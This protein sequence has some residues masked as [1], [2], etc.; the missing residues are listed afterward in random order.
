MPLIYN[1]ICHAL[2]HP[3]RVR[4]LKPYSGRFGRGYIRSHPL[5]VRGLKTDRVRL[6]FHKDNVSHLRV[7]GLTSSV[8]VLVRR[9]SH[10]L[11]VRGLAYKV[12]KT[13]S[14]VASYGCVD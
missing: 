1:D 2:S 10:T 8:G 11:R 3:L 4:G 14:D 6:A 12:T 13:S 5:R 7:R 9:F